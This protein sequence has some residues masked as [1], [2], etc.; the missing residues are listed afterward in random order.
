M[1]IC[2]TCDG[3]RDCDTC[4]GRGF[5]LGGACDDCQGS[6]HCRTCSGSGAVTFETYVDISAGVSDSTEA[7][8]PLTE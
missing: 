3:H 6:G 5:L 1:P 2:P 7:L 4:D 8:H